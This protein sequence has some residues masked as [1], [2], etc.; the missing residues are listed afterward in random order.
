MRFQQKCFFKN[1][2][3]IFVN[4]AF[5]SRDKVDSL[6]T[7]IGLNREVLNG[8]HERL[9]KAGCHSIRIIRQDGTYDVATFLFR[10]DMLSA[11]YYDIHKEAMT[12]TEM[13]AVDAD[14]CTRIVFNPHVCFVYGSPA[15]GDICFPGKQEYLEGHWGK[16]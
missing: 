6:A 12:E 5:P 3:R 10:R 4:Q 11:Y 14:D 8:I 2:F 16:E 1:T 7:V 9:H 13:E 15:F